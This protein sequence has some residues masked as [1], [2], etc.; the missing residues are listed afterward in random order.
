MDKQ[1]DLMLSRDL[2]SVITVREQAAMAEFLHHKNKSFHIMRDHKDHRIEILGGT[3]AVKL[4]QSKTRHLME[5]GLQRML[6][7]SRVINVGKER[8]LDQFLLVR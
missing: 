5:K 4:N 6:Q 8:G 7:D 2:D 1:V 3:W